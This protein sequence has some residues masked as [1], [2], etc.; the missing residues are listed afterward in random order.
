ML[1]LVLRL[2]LL[3]LLAPVAMATAAGIAYWTNEDLAE[4]YQVSLRTVRHW[5]FTGTGPPGIRIGGLVRYDPAEVRAWEREKR[6]AAEAARA[7]VA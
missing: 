4:R 3:L 6:R 5:R 1:R 2:T 7:E